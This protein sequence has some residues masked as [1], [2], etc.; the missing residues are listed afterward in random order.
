RRWPAAGAALAAVMMMGA[1]GGAESPGAAA[2]ETSAV[3]L[4]P[5]DVAEVRVDSIGAA[6]V[7]TGSL[8][9]W[10]RVEVRAQVPGVVLDLRVD[11]GD[12]VRAGQV[13]AR[14]EAEGI[15]GQAEGA[16]AAVAAAEANLALARR[17]YE[18][19]RMLHEAGAMSDIEFEQT[20]AAW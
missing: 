11:R 14:I 17:Q 3:L 9:P 6:T 16:R 1:C 19:A 2:E 4:A 5:E 12:A 15:R 13:L 20:Q 7:L 10:Q 8:E 18:S